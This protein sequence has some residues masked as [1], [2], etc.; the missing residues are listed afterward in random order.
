MHARLSIKGSKFVCFFN[1]FAA[2]LGNSRVPV[3]YLGG[4]EGTNTKL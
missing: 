1:P 2:K 3:K 4:G